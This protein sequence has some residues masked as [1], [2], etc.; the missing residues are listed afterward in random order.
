[1]LRSIRRIVKAVNERTASHADTLTHLRVLFEEG[2]K[3]KGALS[4][5]GPSQER[6]WATKLDSALKAKELQL[7]TLPGFF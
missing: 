7:P 2:R 5:A 3:L 4:L 1:M 6:L